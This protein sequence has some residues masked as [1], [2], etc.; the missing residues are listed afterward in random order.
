[1]LTLAASG[2]LAFLAKAVAVG[3]GIDHTISVVDLVVIS[4]IGGLLSSAIVMVLTVTLAANSVRYSWDLDNVMAP[5]VTA[6]GDMVTLPAL[7]VG[8]F[9]VSIDIVTPVIAAIG[10]VAAVVVLGIALRSSLEIMKRILVESLPVVLVAGLLSLVAGLTLEGQI[11][12]LV[13]YPALLAL[14]PPFLASAGAIGG[15]LSTRLTSKLHLG[16]IDATAVPMRS[17]RTDILRSY[18]VAVPIFALSSVV[19][20][21][22]A[23]LIDLD[24]P[25]PLD[26]VLVA[27]V[28]GLLATTLAIVVAYYG[29]IVSYRMGLDPDNIGIPLV[30]SSIDLFG[31]VS[32]ILAVTTFVP[33]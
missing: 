13:G 3:F 6:A 9:L 33:T 2:G 22:A 23:L 1:V 12:R 19:A 31:S 15:I 26:M 29:A 14:V 8:T 11:V 5:L 27:L 7:F 17:A 20:D 32:F 30:T 28:G 10:V 4:L 21:L 25:G 24:S 18:M 16:V